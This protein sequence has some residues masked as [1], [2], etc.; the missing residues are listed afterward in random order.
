MIDWSAAQVLVTGGAG[1]LG[2]SVV[3]KLRARGATTVFVPRSAE[4][5]LVDGAAVRRLLADTKPTLIVHLAARVGGIAANQDNPGK[6]FYEN[7]MMGVQILHEAYVSGVPK[8][9]AAGTICA[10]PKFCPVP[11]R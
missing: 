7:L 3:K 10:Y 8:V 6:F 1:F 5:D 9:V 4:Y 2:S 11:F